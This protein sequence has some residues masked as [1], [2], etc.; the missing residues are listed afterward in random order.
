MKFLSFLLLLSF[1]SFS[2]F[3]QASA[4]GTFETFEGEAISIYNYPTNKK[5]NLS[6]IDKG[7]D[8]MLQK[9]KLFYFNEAG[10]LQKIKQSE[11]K[12]LNLQ[13]GTNYCQKM[14]KSMGGQKMEHTMEI[15]LPEPMLFLGLPTIKTGR[16]IVLQ[17]VLASSAK[18]ILTLFTND[19]GNGFCYI[20]NKEDY[21]YVDGKMAYEAI[22]YGKSG[23]RAYAAIKK[24]FK[25]CPALIAS[26]EAIKKE[27]KKG[28]SFQ[29]R[30]LLQDA[31]SVS[32]E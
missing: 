21:K 8:C 9:L 13:E 25:D 30:M 1:S 22:G 15:K 6:A 16:A 26:M 27:N 24:Y 18:Y 7:C 2:L 19:A 11:V 4:I 31:A 32:C 17:T 28:K 14:T 3:A 5:I 10:K 29:R 20:Y 12:Q 23:E